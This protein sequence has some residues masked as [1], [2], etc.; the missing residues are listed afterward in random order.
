MATREGKHLTTARR[1]W[2]RADDVRGLYRSVTDIHE[3][4]PGDTLTNVVP[5][6]MVLTESVDY[7]AAALAS[8]QAGQVDDGMMIG[9]VIGL[10]ESI[11]DMEALPQ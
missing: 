9:Y 7:L 3:A 4:H 2:R 6:P 8:W 1:L 10:L 5:A 11:D